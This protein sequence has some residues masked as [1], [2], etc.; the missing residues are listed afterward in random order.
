MLRENPLKA[1]LAAGRPALGC[2][3]SWAYPV[4]AELIGLAGYDCAVIDH[5]HGFG[6]LAET[7]GCLQALSAAGSAAVVRVPWNDPVPIKRVL[8]LGV[9]GVMIPSVSTATEA[10]AAVAACRYPPR[11]VRGAAYGQARA[12]AYGLDKERYRDT[13]DDALL[14]VCQIETVQGVDNVAEIAAVDGVD[15]L[16][17]GPYDLSGSVGRLGRFDDAQVRETIRRAERSIMETGRW[18]GA[19]PSLGR[20]PA[21]MVRDGAR[22]VVAGSDAGL[23]RKAA[24]GEVTAFR[25]DL[26][27]ED[28]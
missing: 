10:R 24:L 28:E 23:L 19:L 5:E 22:L 17:V 9:D 14:I 6:G 20:S 7:V 13:A 2:W 21:D 16:F 18:L 27:L 12:A 3:L 4:A 11:G 8:D 1:R 15:V 26:G 25:S